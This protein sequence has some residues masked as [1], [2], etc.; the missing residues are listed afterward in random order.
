ME[1]CWVV[2]VLAEKTSKKENLRR[3]ERMLVVVVTYSFPSKR[4]FESGWSGQLLCTTVS[5]RPQPSQPANRVADVTGTDGRLSYWLR[6]H[7][8]SMLIFSKVHF[9]KVFRYVL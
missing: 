4:P 8:N 7:R 5:P 3:K 9:Q 2:F 6:F 1:E